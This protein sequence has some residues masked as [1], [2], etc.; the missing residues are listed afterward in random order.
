MSGDSH[1]APEW[2]AEGSLRRDQ[3]EKRLNRLPR[4]QLATLPTPLQ[5][6]PRLS[7]A[8][9]GPRLFVKRDDLT[10][11]AFGGNK[12]R[13]MEFF[14]GDALSKGA[15]V[16]I[17]GGAYAQS[18]HA[19]ICAAA[20]RAAG[21]KPVIVVRPA[22]EELGNVGNSESGNAL[23]T[24][25]LCDDVR[26]APELTVATRDRLKELEA[27][28][29][30]FDAIAT[31]YSERG[32]TPYVLLGTSIGL[33]VMGYVTAALEL[34]DQFTQ[35]SIQPDWVVVTSLGVTQAGLEL[36]SRLLGFTWRV[37]GMA[38]MPVAGT[39]AATV[40]KLIGDAAELLG[41]N[42]GVDPVDIVNFDD[43]AGPAYGAPSERSDR[44]LQAAARLEALMFDPVYSAKGLAGLSGAIDRGFFGKNETVVFVHTGGLP[45]LF[46]YPLA[47]TA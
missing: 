33:G 22:T 35:S 30:V 18:N 37:A 29:Q 24:R 11:L 28:R 15:D 44:V 23:L 19:R 4:H 41:L 12:V 5:E 26:V 42:F 16:L 2:I 1:T 38:Y 14:I 7:D 25:L 10:G 27:R 31:E 43:D 45:S 39:G 3:L 34:Q 9:G 32:S 13:Q 8:L 20:S 40:S 47:P 21:I 46:A 17:G 6:F 36:A